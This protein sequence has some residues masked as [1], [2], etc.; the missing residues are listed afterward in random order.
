MQA[1]ASNELTTSLS[2]LGSM[3]FSW[4]KYIKV[5]QRFHR[6]EILWWTRTLQAENF[7]F[8]APLV[9]YGALKSVTM[10]WHE[11]PVSRCPAVQH[12]HPLI[13]WPI[14]WPRVT[15]LTP[16]YIAIKSSRGQWGGGH[17]GFLPIHSSPSSVSPLWTTFYIDSVRD[18]QSCATSVNQ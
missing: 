8:W 11:S 2:D 9:V 7:P 14:R 1:F 5:L 4:G 10:S 3:V 18:K 6:T 17:I 12:L 15:S 13:R 16:L